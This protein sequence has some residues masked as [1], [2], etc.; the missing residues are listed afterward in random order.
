MPASEKPAQQVTFGDVS[1]LG[2]E[3][4]D[5]VDTVPNPVCLAQEILFRDGLII[6]VLAFCLVRRRNLAGSYLGKNLIAVG[7][8]SAARP[9]L[10]STKK[11]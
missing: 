8:G 2:L 6:S 11:Q 9:V 3:L 4:M 1:D 5:T 7:N 10:S